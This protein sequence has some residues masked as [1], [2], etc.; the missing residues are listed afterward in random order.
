MVKSFNLIEHYPDRWRELK[1]IQAICDTDVDGIDIHTLQSLWDCMEQELNNSFILP[2]DNHEGMDEY[3]CSRWEK[4]LGITPSPLAET[5]DRQFAIYTRL[6][7]MTPYSDENVNKTLNSILG[8]D[9]YER[10]I[11]TESLTYKIVLRLS[12]RF[13]VDSINNLMDNI[14]PANMILITDIRNTTHEHLENYEHEK[15]EPY[16]HYDITITEFDNNA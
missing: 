5:S 2:Y 3:T 8:E 12:S 7:Q 16:S 4:M 11:D 6:L 10:D 1:E 9:E 13:M 14:V 15:L